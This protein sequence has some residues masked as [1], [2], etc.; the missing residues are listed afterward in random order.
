MER[1]QKEKTAKP[2]SPEFRECAG[3]LVMEYYNEDQSE[4]EAPIAIAVKLVCPPKNLR[5]WVRQIQRDGDERPGHNGAEKARIKELERD[6]RELP[7]EIE[8]RRIASAYFAQ[9]EIVL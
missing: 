5:V 2:N 9:A 8:T 3:R 7:Q 6:V 1:T 4:A